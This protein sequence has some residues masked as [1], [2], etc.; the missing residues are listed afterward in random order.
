MSKRNF[1]DNVVVDGTVD[2]YGYADEPQV[3]MTFNPTG[4]S[5]ILRNGSDKCFYSFNGID[6]HGDLNGSDASSAMV[7]DQRF[8]PVIFFR[9]GD[10]Y[11]QIRVEGWGNR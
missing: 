6:D 8:E 7:F 4:F 3:R 10:G 1:Y 2:G 11:S 5:L 9:A